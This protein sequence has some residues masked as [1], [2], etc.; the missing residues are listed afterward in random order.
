M[1]GKPPKAIRVAP[2]DRRQQTLD[3]NGLSRFQRTPVRR[4]RG[5]CPL[6][7]VTVRV[8]VDGGAKEGQFPGGTGRQ[9]F[10]Q[11]AR[12]WI[13]RAVS[14][15]AALG[16]SGMKFVRMDDEE[17]P[18][19]CYERNPGAFEVAFALYNHAEGEGFVKV[20]R[21]S[22]MRVLRRQHIHA[23][24]KQE[25]F[26]QGSIGDLQRGPSHCESTPV[27]VFRVF[28]ELVDRCGSAMPPRPVLGDWGAV[29][30]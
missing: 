14:Q 2:C 23:T 10:A 25:V 21:E 11:P 12:A 27:K 18:L 29:R 5:D 19:A 28:C 9:E 1:I 22:L 17:I 15:A 24:G 8:A 26:R 3:R 16:P 13:D 7:Q 30:E 6:E 4:E 20:R